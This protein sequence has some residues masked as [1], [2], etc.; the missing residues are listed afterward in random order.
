MQRRISHKRSVVAGVVDV[1]PK[2]HDA[3]DRTR[4]VA[5]FLD[6]GDVDVLTPIR[7]SVVMNGD[8]ARTTHQ[9]LRYS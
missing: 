8:G 6:D 2:T 5:L 7:Q 9:V 4:V 1:F 3:H